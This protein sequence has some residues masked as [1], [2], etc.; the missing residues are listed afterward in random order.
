MARSIIM[1]RFGMTQEEATIVRWIRHEGDRVENGDPICEVTTDKVNMEVEAPVDGILA[2]LKYAEGETVPV[3]VV[4]GYVLAEGEALPEAAVQTGPAI[5][6]RAAMQTGFQA[7]ALP[8]TQPAK[9]TPLARRMANAEQVDLAAVQGSGRAGQ[10]TRQDVE[11]HLAGRSMA[12]PF[13]VGKVPASPAARRLAQQAG[14]DLSQVRGSGPGGRVQ[15]WD[16]QAAHKP[17]AHLGVSNVEMAD[18][19]VLADVTMQ[20]EVIPLEGMRR[21]IAQRMQASWQTIPH[22]MFSLEIDM[23]QAAAMREQFNLRFGGGKPVVSLTAVLVKACAAA[24]RQHPLLNSYFRDDHI[25]RLPEINIGVA[26]ALEDGL[27]VPVVRHA[28]EKGLVAVGQEVA[29]L[30]SRARQGN[31][32]PQDVMDGTFT[33]S[34]LGMFGVDNFTAILNPPQVAIL[35][36]G[37]VVK[38][39]IPNEAGQPVLRPMMAVT[40][41]VDHRA[42]DG[43]EAARFLNTLRGILETAGVQWG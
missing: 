23:S 37:R 16:I 30:S 2:G 29:G 3:T 19:Q 28:D 36:V 34:N 25:L 43:A 42:V 4:I 18:E 33:I 12:T 41:S 40:L 24:L 21:T 31:L 8:P 14:I 22:I 32:R 27:I 39:F 35:A 6:A 26:V 9:A 38:R 10:V 1:P 7:G 5:E 13:Q 20:P 11:R 17:A 15:G